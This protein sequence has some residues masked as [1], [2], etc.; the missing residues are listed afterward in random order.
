MKKLSVVAI[1][2]FVLSTVRAQ[3]NNFRFGIAAGLNISN[4]TDKFDGGS[5]TPDSRVGFKAYLFFDAPVAKNFSIQPEVGYDAMGFKLNGD[6]TGGGSNE[7]VDAQVNYLSIGILP[8]IKVPKTGLAFFAGPSISIL[9]SSKV[10]D[11]QGNSASNQD[12]Y[13]SMDVFANVGAEYFLP[14]GLGFTARYMGGLTN[15]AKDAQDGETVH[16]HAFSFS[17]AYKFPS[18]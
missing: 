13:N 6:I 1:F 15:I 9:L 10:S 17:V 3:N 14:I 8:K 2:L 5:F 4:I 11:N 16:N 18:K 12:A 7:S